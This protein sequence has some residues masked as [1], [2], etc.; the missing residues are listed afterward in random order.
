MSFPAIKNTPA[1]KGKK[2]YLISTL[3]EIRQGKQQKCCF[4]SNR[5]FC[6]S[7]ALNQ[8][9]LS[10]CLKQGLQPKVNADLRSQVQTMKIKAIAPPQQ[11]H[12]RGNI[13]VGHKAKKNILQFYLGSDA[14]RSI[15]GLSMAYKSNFDP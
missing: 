4:R 3:L 7:S 10:D 5:I 13:S 11:P 6:L 14:N 8:H 1:F 9:H 15:E 12:K 2:I